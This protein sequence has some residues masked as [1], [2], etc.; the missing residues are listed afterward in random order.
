MGEGSGAHTNG[1]REGQWVRDPGLTL[2]GKGRAMGE[3]SGSHTD[4]QGEGHGY[5][6]IS[7]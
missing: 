1:G 7:N 2:M 6:Q 4:G 3:G 5:L